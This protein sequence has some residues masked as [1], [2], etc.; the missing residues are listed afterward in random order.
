MAKKRTEVADIDRSMY[1]FRY[2]EEGFERVAEGLTPD[3]VRE[4][5]E[6]KN[7]P[8]WMLEHRLKSLEIYNQMP[9]SDW[10][11]A[12]D[13]LDMDHIVTYVK[14]NTDQRADWDS[15]P[16]DIKNT[17]ERLGIPEAER[18]YLAGVGAQYDSELVYHSMQ[19]AAS[20]MGI[21]Y[22]GIEEA[23]DGPYA[24]L[25]KEKFMTLIP[26]TDHKFAA[27]HGA[28][29]S[30]GSF[31]YVPKGVKLDYPLQSYFRLNASGAG[32]FEH[33]LIIVED[34][35]DLH[36][37][38]GCSAPKY[39]VANLHAGAVELFIGKNAHLRY[40]T[41]E[42]WSKNMYN[43]NT[44][45]SI[46]D[47]G[48]SIE[49]I[50]GSFGSHV[51]YL[52][53]M[54]ILAGARSTS[55]FTGITFA[56]AGQ[57]LDTGCKVVMAA[58]DT[59]AAVETKSIS[60]DGGVSTFRSSVVATENAHGSAATVS[61]QSLMLDDISRSDTIPA[62]DIRCKDIDVGHEATIGRIG[63]E[64]I[65]YLMSRGIPE[66]EARTMIVNGFADPVSKE[67]PLEYAVEMNNLIKLE[68]EGAIG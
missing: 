5:S 19:D 24:D 16:D 32:Q 58:P 12:I 33:T 18:T 10:G 62:M 22:S 49:W 1:D 27:L 67:L 9:V 52:Y 50:S 25:I 23:L 61:C 55:T 28:V 8:Q 38:E 7:E 60:K 41:I 54:S 57:N 53:P 39:N 40:S 2:G 14:P 64:T 26:P 59:S 45:R 44:K 36:F 35:A 48:G 46:C 34:D 21:V 42:N 4:I 6:R 20:Q 47:E 3:I 17:F 66:E 56:G 68:M 29:W 65:F 63:D 11:P 15:V 13:G 31:V 37:I 43:L 30:G 51:G